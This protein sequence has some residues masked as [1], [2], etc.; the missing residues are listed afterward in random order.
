MF[1]AGTRGLSLCIDSKTWITK[2]GIQQIFWDTYKVIITYMSSNKFIRI[3]A[4]VARILLAFIFIVF[5]GIYFFMPID[6]SQMP[7]AASAAGKF[8][9]GIMATGYFMPFLKAIEV[10]AGV[11]LLFRRWTPLALIVL[12][13]IVVQIALYILFL[14]PE[15]SVMAIVLLVLEAFLV[16]YNRAKFAPLFAR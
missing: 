12:A 8:M 14:A 5:G 9:I 11:M 13:P 3:S 6:Q 16:W 7:D 1:T 15:A 2:F 10:I 4:I